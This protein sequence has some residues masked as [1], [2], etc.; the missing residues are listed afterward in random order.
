M[1][2]KGGTGGR[3][4]FFDTGCLELHCLY[5]EKGGISNGALGWTRRVEL[6]D[7]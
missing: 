3:K 4:T 2:T 1:R 5:Q 7:K 6:G